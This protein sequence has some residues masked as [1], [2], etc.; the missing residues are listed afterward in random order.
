MSKLTRMMGTALLCL[1]TLTTMGT[2]KTVKL[3]IVETSD[4][5]GCF[6]PYDYVEKRPLKGTLARVST[7][8]QRLRGQYGKN[9]LLLE[10]GDILQGQP[11]CYWTNYVASD[12]ENIAASVVNYLKYDAQAFGNHDVETG[13]A[14]YDKWVREV[15]CPVLGANIVDKATGQPYVKP[16]AIFYRDGVKIAVLG[17]LTPTIACWLNESLW[18]GLEFRDMV[19]S[20]RQWMRHLK[21]VEQPDLIIGLFHS[22][23][24]GGIVMDNGLEEDATA[25]VAREVP[26]FDIIFYGHDHIQHN[27]RLGN[28]VLTLNPSCWALNVADAE[29]TLTYNDGRLVKK[30]ISGNVVSVRNEAVDERMV[31]HFRPQTDRIEAYVNRRIGRFETGA[32][33]RDSYFGSSAFTD[34]IH[35]IQLQISGADISFN[36]PLSFDSRIE[37]GDVTVADMFKLYRFEN[38]YYVLRMRGKEVRGFL[39][40]SYDRWV[41]T[42]RGPEDHLLLLNDESQGDQQRMGFRNYTFNFD[43]AAGIVYVVDVSKPKGQKVRITSMADGTPFDENREYKVVMNS[44]RGNGGGDLLTKGAGIAKADIDARIVYQSPLDLRHYIM[45][46]IERMGNVRPEPNNNWRFIPEEWTVPAAKRDRRLIF[47]E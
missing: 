40:E 27:E 15:N 8:V 26:G 5:H 23:K 46:E 28:D 36:A 18:Q 17:L 30:D 14:V 16:Y 41:D 10:N 35:N 24:D 39:E 31:S 11:T 32:S 20:A 47:G 2:T 37:P 1:T 33:T 12:E 9:L 43:S 34:F 44:Y 6:F 38:Q 3:R 21:E 19:E 42:M 22:G 45:K 25:R 4:V 7:Y 29:V 13:H